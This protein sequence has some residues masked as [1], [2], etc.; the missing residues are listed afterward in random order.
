MVCLPLFWGVL[1]PSLAGD[2]TSVVFSLKWFCPGMWSSSV[3]ISEFLYNSKEWLEELWKGWAPE[4]SFVF[5][6]LTVSLI[7]LWLLFSFLGFSYFAC[8]LGDGC[9]PEVIAQALLAFPWLKG[10]PMCFSDSQIS[11]FIPQMSP[12][13]PC[14]KTPSQNDCTEWSVTSFPHLFH[15]VISIFWWV[16]PPNFLALP[17]TGP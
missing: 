5:V 17:V 2:L 13:P 11:V 16:L 12:E 4:L 3:P 7:L 8:N 14:A 15:W 9:S 6:L 1:S 10:V